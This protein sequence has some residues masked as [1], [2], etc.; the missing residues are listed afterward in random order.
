MKVSF[1]KSGRSGRIAGVGVAIAT[2]LFLCQGVAPAA[3]PSTTYSVARA[4]PL[5]NGQSVGQLDISFVD[6]FARAYFLADDANASLD[7]IDLNT[8]TLSQITPKGATAFAGFPTDP[9]VPGHN[10]ISGPNGVITVHHAEVWLGDSPTFSGPITKNSNLAT[11]YVN[12]NCN[13]SAKVV[14]ILDQTVTDVINTGGCFRADELDWDPKDDVVLI[15][16]PSEQ[17]IG[18]ASS[19][20][21]ITLISS[22]P[23]L[24]GAHHAILKQIKFDGTN[25]TPNAVGGVE[26]PAYSPLTGMFYISIPQ[27]G[28]GDTGGNGAVAVVDPVALRVTNVFPLIGCAP[29]GAAMGPNYEL[30]LG[31]SGPT[32]IIDVRTGTQIASFPQI[33]GCDEVYYN[34]GDNTFGGGCSS[35]L[36]IVNNNTN[37]PSFFQKLPGITHSANAD[38]VS[39]A[40]IAPVPATSTFTN[41][42]P[43]PNKGC[44]AIFAA[45]PPI[46]QAILTVGSASTS[47]QGILAL[48]SASTSA[49]GGLVYQFTA[50]PGASGKTAVIGATPFTGEALVFFTSGPG[51]YAVQ[52]TV[53]DG[54]G[55]SATSAPVTINYTGQ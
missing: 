18:K 8:G 6:P 44:I 13:S 24:P 19:V 46:T 54:A 52:L 42:G 35:A 36:G 20:P 4:I 43:L 23:V 53:T 37:P 15:A 38:A 14:S 1:L 17:N 34:P 21:F 11:A 25:G 51:S 30:Y 29:N 2:V 22:A 49:S 50:V 7:V 40:V 5:P 55:N 3:P 10:E 41:C 39:S 26:Q 16:N 45:G 28:P 9:N 48:G 27:N 32:Q 31:C 12:D 33:T 47:Q